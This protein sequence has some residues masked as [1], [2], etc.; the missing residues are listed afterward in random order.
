MTSHNPYLKGGSPIAGSTAVRAVGRTSTGAVSA[1]ADPA[2]N[3]RGQINAYSNKDAMAIIASLLQQSANGSIVQASKAGHKVTAAE[4]ADAHTKLVA[5]FGDRNSSNFA[6]FGEE[7]ADTVRDTAARAGFLRRFLNERDLV[8]QEIAKIRLRQHSVNGLTVG[9][10]SKVLESRHEGRFFFPEEV[11]HAAR[12]TINEADLYKEGMGLLDEKADEGLESIMVSEDRSLKALFDAAVSRTNY[13]LNF[14]TFTPTVFS[15]LK[16]YVQNSG[17]L[18]VESCWMANDL[19]NDF[20]TGNND[21]SDFFSPVEKHEL[22]LVGRIGRFQDVEIHTDAYL[23]SRLRVLKRGEIY[24][25]ANPEF[26]GEVLVRAALNSS[27][28][29]GESDGNLWRGWLLR[30]ILAIG[31][32][33]VNGVSRGKR[34]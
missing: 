34:I 17:G 20:N 2:V 6:I 16:Q 33:N 9:P 21:F 11:T 12:P 8:A 26:L 28:I 10:Q 29:D 5:S 23:E 25:A 24:F 31:I 30:E 19:W 14:S 7:V 18:P 4:K 3:D 13:A 1:S 27:E 22:A 32:A 15:T